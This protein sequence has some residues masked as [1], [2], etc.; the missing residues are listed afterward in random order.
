MTTINIE[1]FFFFLNPNV[2]SRFPVVL[3]CLCNNSGH[4]TES[5]VTVIMCTGHT[6]HVAQLRCC[7]KVEVSALTGANSAQL[8]QLSSGLTLQGSSAFHLSGSKSTAKVKDS[9]AWPWL[10]SRNIL[11]GST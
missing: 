1:L 3:E 8:R 10:E 4:S 7:V 9:S 6:Q 5:R 11:R 2:S